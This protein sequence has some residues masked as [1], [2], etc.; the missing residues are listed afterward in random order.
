V[1]IVFLAFAKRK[2]DF[3]KDIELL[4]KGNWSSQRIISLYQKEITQS[5]NK[6]F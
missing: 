3:D 2:F 4:S 1:G 5:K 6:C